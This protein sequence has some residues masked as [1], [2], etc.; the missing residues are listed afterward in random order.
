MTEQV[1]KFNEENDHIQ[2]DYQVYSENYGQM[3]D[4]A[5]STD[6]APEVYQINNF[7]QE[8]EK[9][10]MMDLSSYITEEYKERFDEGS[11]FEGV[12][13]YDG[14]IYSLDVYKRQIPMS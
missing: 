10:Y 3:L 2:I 4:L 12:N 1:N 9:G 8:Y 14:K 7:A 11:F 5:F 6:S 13:M